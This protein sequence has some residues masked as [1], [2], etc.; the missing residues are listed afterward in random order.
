MPKKKINAEKNVIDDP[1]KPI[2]PFKKNKNL[3]IVK[4][5]NKEFKVDKKVVPLLKEIL[6]A[7]T[8]ILDIMMSDKTFE[9]VFYNDEDILDFYY[10]IGEDNDDIAKMIVDWNIFTP[11]NYDFDDETDGN[12]FILTHYIEIPLEQL[13]TL[14]KK[15]QQYNKNKS[16]HI[17]CA[18]CEKL[19]DLSNQPHHE[20][21]ILKHNGEDI[22]IDNL[23]VPLIKQIW[24]AGI[25]T[26][27][28][29]ED[30]NPENYIWLEFVSPKDGKKFLR[31]IR[32][33]KNESLKERMHMDFEG[34]NQWYYKC[35]LDDTSTYDEAFDPA[36]WKLSLLFSVRFPQ[37][38]LKKVMKQLKRHNKKKEAKVIVV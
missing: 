25:N 24:K 29:C 7:G 21:T 5:K 34:E 11:S 17:H 2:H 12:L 4:D 23:I 15:L 22:P 10:K 32:K 28:S 8:D 20:K 1:E 26:I 14:Y 27:Q 33:T 31:I 37:K 36:E 13:D 16:T 19:I 6:K 30:N 9:L 35:I 38:D 3:V 18:E